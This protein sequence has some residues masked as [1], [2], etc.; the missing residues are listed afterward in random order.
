[1][2]FTI[3]LGGYC[4]VAT[5]GSGLGLIYNHDDNNDD[6]RPVLS[7]FML[8]VVNHKIICFN[9]NVENHPGKQCNHNTI[10]L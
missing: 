1:M 9:R 8:F 10:W 2:G 7:M 3:M 6:A 4:L 5:T